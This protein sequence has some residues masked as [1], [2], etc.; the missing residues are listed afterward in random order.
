MDSLFAS[1]G[2]FNQ[3]L[4]GWNVSSVTS[5]FYM[6]MYAASFNQNIDTWKPGKLK[7]TCRDIF[8]DGN[9]PLYDKLP[10]WC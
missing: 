9:T 5:M 1:S 2:K 8:H 6:F 10:V 7:T 4:A 3:P